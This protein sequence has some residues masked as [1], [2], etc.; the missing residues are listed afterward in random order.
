MTATFIGVGAISRQV[1]PL[2]AAIGTPRIQLVD[3]DTVESTNIATQG[4]RTQDLGQLKVDATA[5]AIQEL[6]DSIHVTTH[7]D[8]YRATIPIGEAVFCCVDS[9]STRAAIWRSV[10][11]NVNS[12]QMEEC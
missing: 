6:D 4:Y 12:G 9:I 11:K 8:R 10:N 5:R 7:N 2:L 3:F 1:D